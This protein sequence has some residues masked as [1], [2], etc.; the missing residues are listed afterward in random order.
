MLRQSDLETG[1]R[2]SSESTATKLWREADLLGSAA[3][4]A[5]HVAANELAHPGVLAQKFIGS[6]FAGAALSA[7][8]RRAGIIGLS[9]EVVGAALTVPA[10][11]DGSKRLQESYG[12]IKHTWSEAEAA[13]TGA[14]SGVSPRTTALESDKH[15]LASAMGSLTGDFLVSTAGGLSGA[16]GTRLAAKHFSRQATDIH[17]AT[18]RPSKAIQAMQA[19]Q[20]EKVGLPSKIPLEAPVN[21]PAPI[22]DAASIDSH[23][24]KNLTG[25]Y[26]KAWPSIIHVATQREGRSSFATGF[27]VTEKGHM[28]T[29][30]HAIADADKVTLSRA[31]GSKVIADLEA[32]DPGAD[33]ALFKIHNGRMSY[34][35]DG[36]QRWGEANLEALTLASAEPKPGQAV[37]NLGHADNVQNVGMVVGEISRIVDGNVQ[38]N[39]LPAPFHADR[40]VIQTKIATKP[41]FSGGPLLN[42]DGE[43]VGLHSAGNG[44]DVGYDI[45]ASAIRNS[46]YD[47]EVRRSPEFWKG[48]VPLIKSAKRSPDGA[49]MAMAAT[50]QGEADG[51]FASDLSNIYAGQ[52][53]RVFKV[54]A[55][56]QGGSRLGTALKVTDQGHYVTSASLVEGAQSIKLNQNGIWSEQLGV[57]KIL[58]ES[59]LAILSPRW[60]GGYSKPAIISP[61][62]DSRNGSSRV[63]A[64]DQT[65]VAIGYPQKLFELHASVGKL[66]HFENSDSGIALGKLIIPTD[67]GLEGAPLFNRRGQFVGIGTFRGALGSTSPSEVAGTVTGTGSDAMIALPTRSLVEALRDITSRKK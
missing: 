29:A 64:Q 59:N 9:A 51:G 4:E 45:P 14:A 49:V 57:S 41:G 13:G 58:P 55:V 42:K 46:L 24:D 53:E 6:T 31:D 16:L 18:L 56:T 62:L 35:L 54:K 8:Q 44:V 36:R 50:A 11:L 3:K 65:L 27:I 21:T 47:R 22:F 63:I 30:F 28:A 43:V 7:M 40:E 60:G 25:L 32:V 48:I 61:W 15:K 26:W 38:V 12:A 39:G 23:P 33:L 2:T 66:S 67:A 19:T 17:L 34:S 1:D 10:L 37:V 5:G 20:G 52:H